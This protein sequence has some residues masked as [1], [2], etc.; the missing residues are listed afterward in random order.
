MQLDAGWLAQQGEDAQLFHWVNT[1][2][3]PQL[4]AKIGIAV[5]GGSDS[6][7]LLHLYL[8]WSRQ[9]GHP[10]AAVTVDHGLRDGAAAEAE[11]VSA[12]CT[13]EDVPHDIL[14]W[15]SWDCLLYTSPSPRDK[16]Q[17]R[18]PSSA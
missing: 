2:F 11:K 13:T 14:K 15:G 18:M 4:P 6:M 3:R 5:S 17:S 7:A 10:I 16:R 12:F 9:T 8:Q 1:G